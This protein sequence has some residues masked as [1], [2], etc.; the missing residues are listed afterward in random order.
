MLAFFQTW[1]LII[2]A[3]FLDVLAIVIIKMRLNYLGPFNYE[4]A[5]SVIDY[6]INVLKTPQTFMSAV[7]LVVTPA[8][9]GFA[10]SKMNLNQ[11]YPI[12]IGLTT[13]L[14][15]LASIIFLKEVMTLKKL[16]GVFLI[17]LGMF[18]VSNK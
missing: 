7:F 15:L 18:L 1:G 5:N 3:A 10:L 2:S 13:V 12:L 17:L 16:L 6:A 4:G 14:M 8:L 11:V 9:F